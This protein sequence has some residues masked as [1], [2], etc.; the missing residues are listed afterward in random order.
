MPENQEFRGSN[1]AKHIP[2][3]AAHQGTQCSRDPSRSA[4]PLRSRFSLSAQCFAMYPGL[5]LTASAVP[6]LPRPARRAF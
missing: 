6:V 5:G 3:H 1:G 2:G 4:R